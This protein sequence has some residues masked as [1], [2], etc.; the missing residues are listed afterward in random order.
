MPFDQQTP[1]GPLVN[2]W[3]QVHFG[4]HAIASFKTALAAALSLWLGHLLRLDHTYWAAISAIVVTGSDV[5]VTFTSC[6]DRIIGTAIGALIGW[7]TAYAWHGHVLLYGFSVAVCVLVCSALQ[8]HKA[9]H[10]AAV[11]LTVIVLANLDATP[12]RAAWGRFLEVSLGIIVALVV[13][14]LFT[15]P[16][17]IKTVVKRGAA[18][19]T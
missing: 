12:G 6:L 2:C 9:G 4:E 17:S 13:T 3:Q 8:F 11:A 19:Q 15:P 1:Q 10:L 5:R 16:K 7:A 18:D 14:L